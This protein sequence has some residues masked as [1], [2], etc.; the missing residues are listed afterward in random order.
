[1]R[2]FIKYIL[3]LLLFISC[4]RDGTNLDTGDLVLDF[5]DIWWEPVGSSYLNM[6]DG[7][8]C[9]MFITYLEV[10]EPADGTVLE[11]IEGDEVSYIFS[12]FQRIPGGYHL[13][14]YD[15]DLFVFQDSDGYYIE[16]KYLGLT[17]EL[18]IIPC[19]LGQ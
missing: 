8:V 3:F 14:K 17:D 18:S 15:A 12:D 19:S 16:I 2:G 7:K 10:E 13:L 11:Y 5:E 4:G 6:I 9:L 1:M